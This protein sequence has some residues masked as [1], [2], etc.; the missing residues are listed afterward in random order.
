MPHLGWHRA[1]MTT[2]VKMTR[3]RVISPSSPSPEGGG[4]VDVLDDARANHHPA[5]QGALEA[6]AGTGAQRALHVADQAG[7]HGDALV[8]NVVVVLCAC[9]WWGFFFEAGKKDRD[10]K[11]R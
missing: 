5:A 6:H 10:N 4:R 7:H 8:V 11:E 1:L 2:R 3:A 9:Q